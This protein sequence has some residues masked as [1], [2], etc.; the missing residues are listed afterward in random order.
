MSGLYEQTNSFLRRHKLLEKRRQWLEHKAIQ[1]KCPICKAKHGIEYYRG[2]LTNTMIDIEV[3]KVNRED[4]LDNLRKVKKI[5]HL[6][7]A[8]LG[9]INKIWADLSKKVYRARK[10]MHDDEDE[11]LKMFKTSKR[12]QKLK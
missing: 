3:A 6:K 8:E 9:K 7:E 4:A 5:L 2:V 10:M 11:V 12:V 1:T